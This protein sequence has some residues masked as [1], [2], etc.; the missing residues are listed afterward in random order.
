LHNQEN[1]LKRLAFCFDGTWNQLDAKN[2][3]NVVITAE[4]L[5][6]SVDGIV[7]VIH[8]DAGVGTAKGQKYGGGLLGMGVLTNI[9]DAY[10]FLV[11][12]YEVGDEIYIFGFS[13]GAFT[14]RSFAGLLRNC[15][16]VKHI[17]ASQISNVVK[18]YRDRPAKE[19]PDSDS[20]REFRYNFSP[21]I[22]VN[23][24]EDTWRATRY[25]NYKSGTSPVLRIKYLGVW[26]TVGALGVPGFLP[27]AKWADRKFQFHDLD[28]TDMVVSARHAV[29]IDEQRMNFEPTL[30]QNFESLN[31]S[32]GFAPTNESA[33]Y[34]QKWFPGVH[35]SVGGG[36]NIRGLSDGALNWIIR[37][38][39][40]MGLRFAADPNSPIFKLS[41]DYHAP[42]DNT[43]PD[44]LTFKDKMERRFFSLLSRPRNP[45]PDQITDVRTT[46]I[47]RWQ[48]S[49][50]D[51]P[52]KKLYRPP[53]LKG[54]AARMPTG[55]IMPFPDSSGSTRSE[56][57]KPSPDKAGSH[58]KV[59]FGDTLS[60]IAKSVYG[61]ANDTRL[62]IQANSQIITDPNDIYIG[63][64]LYLPPRTN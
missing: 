40:K 56:P 46:A 10:T 44:S 30:W 49:A 16:I 37:G 5:V 39:E 47:Q 53:T 43:T 15:G 58:Y 63:Q 20:L 33:P 52:E 48:A 22:C 12:N 9:I 25:P 38:A 62:I 55:G 45:G 23:Q 36:G 31:H 27:F 7:Q 32:L 60:A 26:D 54:V 14:A 11:L 42:L 34:Q 41:P 61:N 35:G 3:T 1:A 21:L 57:A 51:L 13:R 6:S 29:A 2:P 8:Y 19:S 64:V 24:A 50:A 4:S 59:V 17:N 28:L 18:R